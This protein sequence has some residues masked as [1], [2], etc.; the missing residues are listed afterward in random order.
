MQ[1]PNDTKRPNSNSGSVGQFLRTRAVMVHQSAAA[2]MI[3]NPLGA[4]LPLVPYI[5]RHGITSNVG[6]NKAK[7]ERRQQAAA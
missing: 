3:Q 2:Q 4:H 7:R 5:Q 6:R 1:H